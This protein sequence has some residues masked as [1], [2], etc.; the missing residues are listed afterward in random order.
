MKIRWTGTALDDLA[1]IVA[2]YMAEASPWVAD[3]VQQRIV[4]AVQDLRDF[5]DRI[6]ASER[7]PGTRELVVPKLP[8][9]VF[10]QVSDS[11]I[12]ILNI[13]HTARRFPH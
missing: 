2:Y 12:I 4:A 7:V 5:P 10:V 1:A 3:A 9:I 6:H 13:V 11:A 8:Y